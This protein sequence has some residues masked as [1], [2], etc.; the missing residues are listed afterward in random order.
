MHF[1][2]EYV[3]G[4]FLVIILLIVLVQVGVPAEVK[5][6]PPLPTIPCRGEP[7]NVDTDYTGTVN[8]P[9]TCKVQCEDQKL[10]YIHYA[11]GKAT[12]CEELPGCNDYGED[13]GITCTPPATT[14]PALTGSKTTK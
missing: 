10:R 3:F 6:L 9:W 13:H 14:F 7:I 11:N 8:E 1:R 2:N 4:G 12:Q 5:L